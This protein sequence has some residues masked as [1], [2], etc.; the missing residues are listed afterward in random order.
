[1]LAACTPRGTVT[2]TMAETSPFRVAVAQYS[3]ET[4][5]FCPGGDTTIEDWTHLGPV[6]KG[7]DLLSSG[8][9]VGGFVSA[10]SDFKDVELVGLTSPDQVFGGSSRS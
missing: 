6:L 4:C 5:T 9:F 8:G 3:H 1:M 2:T 7:E 10:A